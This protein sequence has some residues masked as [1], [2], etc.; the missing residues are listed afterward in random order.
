MVINAEAKGTGRLPCK[1]DWCSIFKS[2]LADPSFLK[3]DL[4]LG[5]E[6][7]KPG[8]AHAVKTVERGG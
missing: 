8:G 7:L 1:D 2:T 3:V 6:L 4:Q 5:V